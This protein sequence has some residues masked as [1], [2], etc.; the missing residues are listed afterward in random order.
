MTTK[1]LTTIVSLTLL[2][3]CQPASQPAE[4]VVAIEQESHIAWFEGTVEEAFEIALAED[5]PLFLYWGAVWCPP[6]HYLKD[7]VF[8]KPEF[9]AQSRKFV[10]VYLDGDTDRAQAWGEKLEISGYPT[11]LVLTPAGEEVMRMS[12]GIPVEEY[13]GVLQAALAQMRPIKQVLDDVLAGGVANADETALELLAN[14][15]W[16]TG[17]DDRSRRR[18]EISDLQSG[19]TRGVRANCG[20][21]GLGS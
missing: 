16:G 21:P 7:K 13:N 3:S 11:V 9:V 18:G 19:S 1:H 6:C 20:A 8:K 14:Y 12:T 15:S 10:A 17:P 2:A 4:D 5:K